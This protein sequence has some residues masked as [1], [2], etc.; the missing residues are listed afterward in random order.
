MDITI[1]A[2]YQTPIQLV[3]DTLREA[4]KVP[5]ILESEPVFAAVDHYGESAIVY[6]LRVWST[7]DDYWT[8]L[9]DINENIKKKFDEKGVAMTYPHLNVHL[10]K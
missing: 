8:T 10:D 5:T 3:L 7:A 9:F 2:S 1:S 6:V 4:G